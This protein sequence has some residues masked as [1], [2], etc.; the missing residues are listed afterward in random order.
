MLLGTSCRSKT[1]EVCEMFWRLLSK[2]NIILAS[3]DENRKHKGKL[4]VQN[5]H[6]ASPLASCQTDTGPVAGLEA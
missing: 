6:H 3:Y 2:N 4:A 5:H 1:H